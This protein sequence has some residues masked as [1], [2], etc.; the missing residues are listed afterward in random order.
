MKARGPNRRE[1]CAG[2]GAAALSGFSFRPRAA[3]AQDN[4]DNCAPPGV[5][6]KN[7]VA[8]K[9]DPNLPVRIRKSA[10]ELSKTEVDRLK[11]AYAALRKLTHDTPDDPRG[12]LRG[13]YVHCWYC[14]GGNDNQAG[15]EIHGS[16]L[17]FPWH[18]AYLHFHERI[19][20]K[21][22]NDDTLAIP[23]WDWDSESRQKFPSVYGDPTDPSNPLFDMLRSAKA[24]DSISDQAVSA[25]I[26]NTT[27]NAP[28]NNLFLG[29]Q[30]GD[31]GAM[32]NAPHGPVH[33]WT[34]DTTMQN[35][36]NDMGV[37]ATAAQ[38][39]LFFAHHGNIDRLWGVWLDLAPAQHKNFTSATWTQHPW[40]FYDENAVWTEI[41]IADVL[42]TVKSLRSEYAKPSAK[43]IWT[44]R[45]RSRPA[46][47]AAAAESLA[48]AASFSMTNATAA[49]IALGVA[50]V[51]R[52]IAIPQEEIHAL[53]RLE[54]AS[55]AQ[56]V[57]YIR[58]I[59]APNDGQ[60]M[61]NV[62]LNLP[63]ATAATSAESPNFV[64]TVTVLAKTKS[65]I[66]RAPVTTNAAFDVTDVLSKLKGIENLSVTLAPTAAGG[67]APRASQATFRQISLE[68][69]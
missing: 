63:D 58:G 14:G 29:S 7:P 47:V 28:N 16:W 56:Y 60:A 26:L 8:Y 51:T 24:S 48:A 34:G 19:L 43:P 1:V 57:L 52:E 66:A 45:P 42:D 3:S 4:P 30:A 22:I 11:E 25:A 10:F 38:D 23:Y 31:A 65:P 46:T 36:N 27:M 20:C 44:F 50:P 13:G 59:E 9:P 21:L 54:P 53:G 32:E 55:P 12:W 5:A 2:L 15:E 67:I 40:Q 49:P 6:G 35:S 33:I 68:R 41:K 18:R 39:P 17:F 61:F 37:L 64:G 69:F 62:F